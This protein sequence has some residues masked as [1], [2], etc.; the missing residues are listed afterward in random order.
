[1]IIDYIEVKDMILFYNTL[2]YYMKTNLVRYN[3]IINHITSYN[4]SDF[5]IL[6][7][8]IIKLVEKGLHISDNEKILLYNYVMKDKIEDC[9]ITLAQI[10]TYERNKDI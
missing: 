3:N 2:D 6:K 9:I 10:I 4:Y 1:M 5:C 8:G 7:K